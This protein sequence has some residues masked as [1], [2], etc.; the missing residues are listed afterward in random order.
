M[1]ES[2]KNEKHLRQHNQQQFLF[3]EQQIRLSSSIQIK[4]IKALMISDRL[5][6]VNENFV[7]S[8]KIFFNKSKRVITEEKSSIISSTK[9]LKHRFDRIENF[10]KIIMKQILFSFNRISKYI[11]IQYARNSAMIMIMMRNLQFFNFL[12]Y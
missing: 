4:K 1:T 11:K 6:F 3:F 2:E 10:L 9:K 5:Y 7:T 12:L 8:R